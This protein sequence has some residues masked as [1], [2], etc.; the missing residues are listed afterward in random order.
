MNTLPLALTA[1]AIATGAASLWAGPLAAE[2]G[3]A[4]LSAGGSY[5]TSRGG[6]AFVGFD[7]ADLF[8]SGL[9]IGLQFETGEDGQAAKLSVA[10]TFDMGATGLGNDS[11][12]RLSYHGLSTDWDSQGYVASDHELEIAFA[13]SPAPNLTYDLRLFGRQNDFSDFGSGVSPLIVSE[14][15]KSNAIGLGARLEWSRLDDELLPH[16]GARFGADLA[17]AT[18][19]GDR[20][21]LSVSV[22]AGLAIP[23]SSAFTL[24]IRA[25]AGH[26][27]GQ[28]GQS[29]AFMDRAFLGSPAPR[30][31]A[32]AGIGPR[33][34]VAGSVDTPL[35]GNSYFTSSVELRYQTAN[36]DLSIGAFVDSG[37]V[38]GLDTVTGGASGTIDD[39]YYLRA[40]AGVSIYWQT[41]IGLMQLNLASP[42]ESEAYDEEEVMS[43][44]ITTK[45]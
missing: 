24:S 42:F 15:V 14:G 2:G 31:F 32:P 1:I 38:W 27:K 18:P 23:V 34:F 8:G 26:V 3:P 10:K 36:P 17:W 25:D 43:F 21:W 11:A 6:L 40:A 37:S 35:G 12:V 28:S 20:E 30:G 44:G 39:S 45:F 5:S 29:V 13:A 9:D 7:A 16:S 4:S 22:S 19:A 41:K 33:D